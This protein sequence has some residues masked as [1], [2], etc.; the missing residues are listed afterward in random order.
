[1]PDSVVECKVED[2]IY[3]IPDSPTWGSTNSPSSPDS[4]FSNTSLFGVG[5]NNY[6]SNNHDRWSVPS[7]NNL[8]W[9]S[10]RAIP[11]QSVRRREHNV[12]QDS[13]PSIQTQSGRWQDSGSG[14]GMCGNSG[15]SDRPR[16]RPGHPYESPDTLRRDQDVVEARHRDSQRMAWHHRDGSHSSRDR[17]SPQSSFTPSPTLPFS[18][19]TGAPAYT[20]SWTP[21]AN[22]LATP[23]LHAIGTPSN[24]YDNNG[25]SSNANGSIG[26]E[27][28][29]TASVEEY[30]EA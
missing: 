22:L 17:R 11:S 12:L 3:Q 29:A 9:T 30:A 26:S 20:S 15:Y 23:T 5:G 21:D 8:S 13:W 7:D 19:Y 2:S 10:S 25:Y 27:D 1:M 14:L 16:V 28:F 4:N 18:S 24:S 6:R